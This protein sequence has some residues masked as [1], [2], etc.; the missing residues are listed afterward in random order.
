[1]TI[2][3]YL[4][5]STETSQERH[6]PSFPR[7]QYVK[8]WANFDLAFALPMASPLCFLCSL[9]HISIE[10]N[11]ENIPRSFIHFQVPVRAVQKFLQNCHRDELS[12]C[13]LN[14]I[15]TFHHISI[16]SDLTRE[17][18]RLESELAIQCRH[19]KAKAP[20]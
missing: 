15:A 8:G 14:C 17:A 19:S 11:T 3:Q 1:M 16:D 6:G 2:V 10:A 4:S 13:G 20:D 7:R 12:S 18:I 5:W 9:I